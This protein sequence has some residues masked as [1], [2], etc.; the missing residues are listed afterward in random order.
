M[1]RNGRRNE[2]RLRTRP[3]P[4]RRRVSRLP[5]GN[6]PD[7]SRYRSQHSDSFE[8]I[9]LRGFAESPWGD[10]ARMSAEY[11]NSV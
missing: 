8:L 10:L 1:A 6:N 4:I 5:M 2:Q 9:V 3:Q 11:W 7:R